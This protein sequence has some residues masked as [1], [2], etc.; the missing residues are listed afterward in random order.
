MQPA[1]IRDQL[2]YEEQHAERELLLARRAGSAAAP[3]AARLRGEL[4][5]LTL[6][7][8]FAALSALA[9]NIGFLLRHRGAV[10]APAV[11]VHRP[12]RS[13]VGLF[14]QK[15]W[16]I[17][18]LIDAVAYVLHVGAPSLVALS[19]V[20]AVLAGGLVIAAGCARRARRRRAR[21]DIGARV[22]P[23]QHSAPDGSSARKS[24]QARS[25]PGPAVVP[26]PSARRLSGRDPGA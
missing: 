3:G 8:A 5:T 20:Q 9:T 22:G 12:L 14:G 7:L 16:T 17:G 19:L 15:W 26:L 25:G 6:G 10:A 18:Y 23:P 11:D 24:C 13:A 2:R 21:M 1:A 4:L